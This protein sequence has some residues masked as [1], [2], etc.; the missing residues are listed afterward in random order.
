MEFT[1]LLQRM[2]FVTDAPPR[3]QISVDPSNAAADEEID[4]WEFEVATRYQRT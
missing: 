4:V 2:S 1:V 3:H